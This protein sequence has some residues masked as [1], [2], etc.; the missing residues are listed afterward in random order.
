[1]QA[2]SAGYQITDEQ[3]LA[4]AFEATTKRYVPLIRGVHEDFFTTSATY[5]VVSGTASYRLP[6]RASS[7]TIKQ[8][9]IVDNTSGRAIP[10]PR[11]PVSQ[12]YRGLGRSSATPWFYVIEGAQLRLVG[13][14]TTSSNY[15]LV[16]YYQ[17]RPS[18]YVLTT[19][20]SLVASASSVM[21]TID[22]VGAP[23][24]YNP[25]NNRLDVMS[26][27]PEADLIM[28]DAV[29]FLSAPTTFTVLIGSVPDDVVAGCYIAEADTTPVVLLPD[30]FI[31]SLID[32]TAAECERSIGNYDSAASLDAEVESTLPSILSSISVRAESQ[33]LPIRNDNAGLYQ[34]GRWYLGG[35]FS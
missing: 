21:N 20:A 13:T 14:P 33:P 16:V 2:P 4:I 35:S 8:V 10:V 28:Q 12:G 5:A 7:T 32:A 11:Q 26:P 24:W 22:T 6:P 31:H 34:R 3:I 17:R 19:Q 25:S 15:T 27:Q 1:V 18:R 9:V 29:V 30:A 23:A